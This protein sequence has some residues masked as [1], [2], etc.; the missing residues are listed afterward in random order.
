MKAGVEAET[1]CRHDA[2][3]ASRTRTERLRFTRALLCQMS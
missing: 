1:L 2:G 3:A